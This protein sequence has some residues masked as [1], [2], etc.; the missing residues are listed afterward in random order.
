MRQRDAKRNSVLQSHAENLDVV[1][2]VR[3]KKVKI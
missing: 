1:S 2:L 3:I